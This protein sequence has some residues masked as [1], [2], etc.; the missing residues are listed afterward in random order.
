MRFVCS[1]GCISAVLLSCGLRLVT[2]CSSSACDGNSPDAR[3]TEHAAVEAPVSSAPGPKVPVLSPDAGVV[4]PGDPPVSNL[5]PNAEPEPPAPGPNQGTGGS[6]SAVTPDPGSPPPG[7]PPPPPDAGSQPPP[8]PPVDAGAP[9]PDPEPGPVEPPPPP[10]P[11]VPPAPTCSDHL[12]NGTESD[13]D[14]GGSCGPCANQARCGRAA[15]CASGFCNAGFCASVRCDDSVQNGN[16]TDQDC[17]GSCTPCARGGR[18]SSSAD[19][20]ASVCVAS[21]CVLG[22]TAGFSVQPL[23]GMAPETVTLTASATIGDAPLVSIE[24]AFGDGGGFGT[25]VTHTYLHA[26][27]FAITQRVTDANGLSAEA[28][29]YATVIENNPVRFNLADSSA[30]VHLSSDGLELEILTSNNSGIRSDAAIAPGSGISYFE[31]ERLAEPLAGAHFGIVTAAFDLRATPGEDSQSLGVDSIGNVHHGGATIAGFSA[32]SAHVGIAV[33]YRGVNPT[34]YVIADGRVIAIRTLSAVTQPLYIFAGGRRLSV[35]PQLRLNTG[36]DT[37]NFPFYYDVASVIG[38]SGGSLTLGWGRT[39]AGTPSQPPALSVTGGGSIA[40]GGSTV[41]T[42]AAN[43]HEDGVLSAT[44]QWTDLSL[45][46]DEREP[47]VGSNFTFSSSVLGIHPLQAR[48]VDSVG[49]VTSTV[50]DVTV[51]GALPQF[52]TVRLEPD[53]RAGNTMALSPDGLSAKFHGSGKYGVRANQGLLGGFQYF[54]MHRLVPPLNQGGGVVIGGGDL[55]PY[56]PNDVPPSCSINHSASIWC[57]LISLADYDVQATSYYGFAVDYRSRFPILYVITETAS[58]PVL[59]FSTQMV[60]VTVPLYP[61]VYGNPT[62]AGAAYDVEINFG[63]SAFH[64]DPRAIL[65]ANRVDVSALEVG[66]GAA[67]TAH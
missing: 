30:D 50:V 29:H 17:G 46:F 21:R 63:A 23:A 28:T 67:N 4:S 40:A 55:E 37:E 36:N 1:R 56:S 42:A 41:L 62:G 39:H 31:A 51:T 38:S 16:E 20:S 26:G 48:V 11:P 27:A 15:D 5:G 9:H 24:Y 19:C 6:P 35:E 57:N 32:A 34:A 44:V 58:G 13:T 14:C 43:D 10:P 66:W 25:A 3:C 18:C 65:Q 2:G 54:E 61:M 64:Y 47:H 52:N 33:D 53:A 8:A 45:P 12:A 49:L 59:S 7:P 22:P 60:N